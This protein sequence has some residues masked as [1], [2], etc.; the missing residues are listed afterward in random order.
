M[1]SDDFDLFGD[2]EVDTARSPLGGVHLEVIGANTGNAARRRWGIATTYLNAGWKSGLHVPEQSV[3][4]IRD[5]DRAE[6]ET[7]VSREVDGK[8]LVGSHSLN[9]DSIVQI[10]HAQ[11]YQQISDDTY[12]IE[13]TEIYQLHR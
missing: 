6:L 5:R 4:G 1:T 11:G 2:I 13:R 8:W 12:G 10:L 7:I 9:R 3:E